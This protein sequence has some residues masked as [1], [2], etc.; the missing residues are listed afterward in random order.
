MVM[1]TTMEMWTATGTAMVRGITAARGTFM[2]IVM[3]TETAMRTAT[4]IAI[5]MGMEMGTGVG[6]ATGIESVY[7]TGDGDGHSYEDSHEDGHRGATG[8]VSRLPSANRPDI[9]QH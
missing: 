1:G 5:W 6:T 2:A 8:I 9:L 7:G 3:E 4:G